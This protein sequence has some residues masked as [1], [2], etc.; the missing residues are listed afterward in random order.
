MRDLREMYPI[1]Q[2]HKFCFCFLMLSL[3]LMQPITF[4]S[5]YVSMVQFGKDLSTLARLGI[6]WMSLHQIPSKDILHVNC[7]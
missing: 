7:S 3:P 4:T 6:A 5:P 1:V 2:G